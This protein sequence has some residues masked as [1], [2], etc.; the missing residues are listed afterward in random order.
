MSEPAHDLNGAIRE[1]NGPLLVGDT[2]QLTRRRAE[3]LAELC[4]VDPEPLWQWGFI[5]RVST[6]LA[7]VRDF[8]DDSGSEFLAVAER[9]V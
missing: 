7:N 2:A 4:E 6:G 1:H 5:E 9:C 8:D 3:R